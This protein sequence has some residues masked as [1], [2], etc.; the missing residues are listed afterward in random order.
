MNR[1]LNSNDTL[2]YRLLSTTYFLSLILEFTRKMA[3]DYAVA[4]AFQ[5]FAYFSFSF[6]SKLHTR[7]EV[8]SKTFQ[9]FDERR[10][11]NSLEDP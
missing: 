2:L 1:N 8:F 9:F 7:V 3:Y 5:L 4:V 10:P 6:F 11:K